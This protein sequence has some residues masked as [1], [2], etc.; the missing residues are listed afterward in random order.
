[1]ADIIKPVAAIYAYGNFELNLET[2]DRTDLTGYRMI[3]YRKDETKAV[4]DEVL[5]E[6]TNYEEA[7]ALRVGLSNLHNWATLNSQRLRPPKPAPVVTLVPA[8]EVFSDPAVGD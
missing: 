2:K 8:P 6:P 3:I 1:M 4:F 5:P 7:E